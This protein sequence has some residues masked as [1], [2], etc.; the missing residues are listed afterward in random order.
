MLVLTQVRAHIYT[1]THTHA[2]TYTD[3]YQDVCLHSYH[4]PALPNMNKVLCCWISESN[5]LYAM[6]VY[7]RFA[8][9]ANVFLTC[10]FPLLF[11][12][13]IKTLHVLFSRFRCVNNLQCK[14]KNSSMYVCTNTRGFIC[15]MHVCG[16]ACIHT[17]ASSIMLSRLC[18]VFK[19]CIE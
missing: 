12:Y 5:F 18:D 14:P 10:L 15:C 9:G 4:V 8:H 17:Y 7:I 11:I 16:H 6:R 1:C 19:Q 2:H 3:T 13:I